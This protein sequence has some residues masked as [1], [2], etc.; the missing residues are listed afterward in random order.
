MVLRDV[1]KYAR[2]AMR[3]HALQVL[4]SSIF[5]FSNINF[6]RSPNTIIY[7]STR[8]GYDIYYI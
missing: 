2:G 3:R 4:K 7:L 6:L 5:K 1:V 8:N